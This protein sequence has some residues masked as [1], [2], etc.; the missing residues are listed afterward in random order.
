ML[1]IEAQVFS[2]ADYHKIILYHVVT[3]FALPNDTI[4]FPTYTNSYSYTSSMPARQLLI[5]EKR[6]WTI[7]GIM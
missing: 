6:K 7:I 1:N 5:F 3:F 2:E 4:S